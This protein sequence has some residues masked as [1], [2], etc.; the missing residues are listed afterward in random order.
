MAGNESA[1][2]LTVKAT[3]SSYS[4]SATGT[5]T[6]TVDIDEGIN[7]EEE[8]ARTWAD[9][10]TA[11][12][13]LGTW[14]GSFSLA[15]PPRAGLE[16]SGSSVGVDIQIGYRQLDTKVYMTIRENFSDL[17]DRALLLD[18]YAGYT[19]NELWDRVR[20]VYTGTGWVVGKYTISYFSAENISDF[21]LS[22]PLK[23]NSSKT[24]LKFLLP[25]ESLSSLE[26]DSD[27]EVALSKTSDTFVPP[28]PSTVSLKN[29]STA[30]GE[31]IERVKILI[32]EEDMEKKHLGRFQSCEAYDDDGE[33]TVYLEAAP[34]ASWGTTRGWTL[35]PGKYCV[36]ISVYSSFWGWYHYQSASFIVANG[37]PVNLKYTG[38][39]VDIVE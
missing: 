30:R 5:A 23:I 34:S 2:T 22:V 28:V 3:W 14:D 7:Q 15:V 37:D 11:A 4:D 32:T 21:L 10:K 39:S 1:G 12:E 9:V 16:L 27:K 17:L 8:D 20:T 13:I 25:K 26:M 35:P 6:V 33:A 38:S 36:K 31:A 19:K 29:E 24:E 18:Q